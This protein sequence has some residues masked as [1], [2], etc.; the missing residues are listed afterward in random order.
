M[1]KNVCVNLN[2]YS[3]FFFIIQSDPFYSSSYKS[4]TRISRTP[5]D[6]PS[7]L[8]LIGTKND[9]LISTLLTRETPFIRATYHFPTRH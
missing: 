6:F 9:P 7:N 5:F 2:T 3:F 8:L 4:R 1:I